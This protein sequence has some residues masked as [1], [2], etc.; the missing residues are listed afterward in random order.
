MKVYK[1]S[2]RNSETVL[3]GKAAKMYGDKW[4]SKGQYALYTYSSISSLLL[5]TLNRFPDKYLSI[6]E[7]DFVINEIEVP[8]DISIFEISRSELPS[9]PDLSTLKLTQKMGDKWINDCNY[10][11]LKVPHSIIQNDFKYIINPLHS[12]YSKVILKEKIEIKLKNYEL[13]GRNNFNEYSKTKS[14]LNYIID[15]QEY[16]ETEESV[17][18][19]KD[20][21]LFVYIDNN[22]TSSSFIELINIFESIKSVS[23]IEEKLIFTAKYYQKYEGNSRKFIGEIKG[24]DTLKLE[25]VPYSNNFENELKTIP[26]KSIK[27]NSP[28]WFEFIFSTAV[29][30]FVFKLIT[31]YKHNRKEKIEI[32][33]LEEEILRQKIENLKSLGY[34]DD[35]VRE[36][37]LPYIKEAVKSVIRL[38]ELKNDKLVTDFEIK[39]EK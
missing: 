6:L 18:K 4:N 29:L 27:Y 19:S 22:W 2:R 1:L 13:S 31:H 33:K 7:K 28:G 10:M 11:I 8:D 30:G 26:I 12:D 17:N 5:S 32:I 9:K 24:G 15:E 25:M 35:Q 36:I 23:S 20:S 14:Y 38:Q 37:M 16:I 3:S 21:S 34:R 39:E